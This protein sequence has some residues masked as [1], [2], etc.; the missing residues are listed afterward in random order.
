MGE[1]SASEEPAAE[2]QVGSVQVGAQLVGEDGC[3]GRD[4]GGELRYVD[5]ESCP[6]CVGFVGDVFALEC[7]DA[8][9][10]EPWV[11]EFG[12]VVERSKSGGVISEAVIEARCWAMVDE[13]EGCSEPRRPKI[14]HFMRRPLNCFARLVF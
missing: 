9:F 5:R 2:A 13:L 1:D 7:V 8:E 11:V 6:R 4:E 14:L 3:V 12:L 10:Q